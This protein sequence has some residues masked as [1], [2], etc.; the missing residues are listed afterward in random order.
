LPPYALRLA[1]SLPPDSIILVPLM[2]VYGV[3]CSERMSSG[4]Y[5]YAGMYTR[6]L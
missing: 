1:P 5:S 2:A 6:R 4:T 3:E